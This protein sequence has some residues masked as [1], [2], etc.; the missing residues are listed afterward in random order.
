MWGSRPCQHDHVSSKVFR[1]NLFFCPT[2]VLFLPSPQRSGFFSGVP[3]DWCAYCCVP[4]SRDF[5]FL[6]VSPLTSL[7]RQDHYSNSLPYNLNDFTPNS[8]LS[9]QQDKF[10]LAR[11]LRS[12]GLF[13]AMV[14]IALRFSSAE[15]RQT[16]SLSLAGLCARV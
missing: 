15:F 1:S 8:D 10:A 6:F 2:V 9:L 14:P 7:L 16:E 11:R 4:G 12:R 5:S 13:F 3:I